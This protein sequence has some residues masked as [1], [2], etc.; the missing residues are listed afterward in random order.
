MTTAAVLQSRTR[1]TEKQV[2]RIAA[3]KKDP[4]LDPGEPDLH[5]VELKRWLALTVTQKFFT[6]IEKEEVIAY[7]RQLS[8]L[9]KGNTTVAMVYTT[10]QNVLRKVLAAQ[11]LERLKTIV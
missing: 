1:S 6:A 11:D 8:N 2:E 9:R 10:E 7:E 3:S 4:P 5:E